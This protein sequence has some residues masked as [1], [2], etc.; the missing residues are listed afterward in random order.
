MG[1]RIRRRADDTAAAYSLFGELC[2][3]LR[4]VA[5]FQMQFSPEGI[6][7]LNNPRR[8]DRPQKENQHTTL[9]DTGAIVRFSD[10]TIVQPAEY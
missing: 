6:C 4:S 1:T 2:S 7:A 9:Q 10:E 8:F 5:R 3:F